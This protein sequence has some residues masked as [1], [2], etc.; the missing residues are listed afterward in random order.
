MTRLLPV[1]TALAVTATLAAAGLADAQ[2]LGTFRWQLQPYC[3]VVVGERHPEGAV[4]TT[5]GYDDQC[6]AAQRA[7]LVGL[8]TPNPDG[9]IGFGLN[10]VTVPGGRA[11]RSTRASAWPAGRPVERQRRQSGTFA[12]GASTGGG[13]RPAPSSGATIP[14]AFA[15]LAD[16][17]FAANGVLNTGTIPATGIGTRMMWHPKKAAFRAGHDHPAWDDVNIGQYS[18]AFGLNTRPP[19][20]AAAASARRPRRWASPARPSDYEPAATALETAWRSDRPPGDGDQRV[21]AGQLPRRSAD[22][23]VGLRHADGATGVES[24]GIRALSTAGQRQSRGGSQGIAGGGLLDGPGPARHRRRQPERGARVDVTALAAATGTFMY[25]DRSTLNDMSVS[26]RP[27]SSCAQPAAR[28]ST[29][30]RR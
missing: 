21:A 23:S 2:P 20:P 3:N 5:D 24:A 1:A 12:F 26:P 7:P 16:G 27:S 22:Q 28:A 11:C 15:L 10:V 30:T 19:D 18:A 4:Y 8:A 6:G 17:G 25:G 9:T 14:G 29:P 13:P